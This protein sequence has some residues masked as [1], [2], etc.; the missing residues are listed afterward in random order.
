MPDLGPTAPSRL[1][2]TAFEPASASPIRPGEPA[3]QAFHRALAEGYYWLGVNAPRARQGDPQGVHHLRTT[4]RRIR[5]ALSLFAGLT[6]PAWADPLAEEF[7]WLAETLGAVRD[8]D[9][10][11]DRLMALADSI[12]HASVVALEP[13]FRELQ[14][15]HNAA[16]DTLRD[17]L[18]SDRF[19]SLAATLASAADQMPIAD[20]GWVPCWSAL[21]PLV[22]ASWKKLRRDARALA[23]DTPDEAFHEVRK[24]AKRARY[25]AE[26]VRDALPGSARR[27][28]SRF[29]RRVRAVQDILGAH[30]DAVIA[31][32][33]LRQS[34]AARPDDGPFNF[35]AGRVMEAEN[36]VASASRARF[37][38]VWAALDR[39][40]LTR[41][42]HP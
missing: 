34:A 40:K 10:M 1:P 41:W 13:L 33:Q 36:R 8:I 23:P 42:L 17:A 31:A 39:R 18:M 16:S 9:V 30:Q 32:E 15:R 5:T 24:R 38:E 29:A 2:V 3:I 26:A 19:Q 4:T 25:A 21:P 28:A 11:T 12:D 37:F 7:R 20:A 27:D 6:E 35:A 22:A 14:G